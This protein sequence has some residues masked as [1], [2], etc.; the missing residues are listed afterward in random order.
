MWPVMNSSSLRWYLRFPQFK[1]WY[2][3]FPSIMHHLCVCFSWLFWTNFLIYV[4]V[5][6]V[7][8]STSVYHW[9]AWGRCSVQLTSPPSDWSSS[10]IADTRI[11]CRW[12]SRSLPIHVKPTLAT[13]SSLF[14]FLPG[15][16]SSLFHRD[17]IFLALVN[18]TVRGTPFLLTHNWYLLVFASCQIS[19]CPPWCQCCSRP[20]W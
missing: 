15:I 1:C 18:Y 7:S 12:I 13:F 4:C 16:L 14:L 5:I 9:A 11:H 3:V 19:T 17:A 6:R 8:R 2:K 20:T 10:T